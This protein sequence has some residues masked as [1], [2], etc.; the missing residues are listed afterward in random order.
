MKT[1]LTS[2]SLV[3]IAL[4]ASGVRSLS[5]QPRPGPSDWTGVWVLD[6][7]AHAEYAASEYRFLPGGTLVRARSVDSSVSRG[8]GVVPQVG[9]VAQGTTRCEFGDRWSAL[10]GSRVQIAGVCSDGRP[11]GIVLDVGA[12]RGATTRRTPHV[13]SV[14]GEPGW[15]HPGW[16]WELRRC[17]RSTD[18]RCAEINDME[19]GAAGAGAP[20]TGLAGPHGSVSDLAVVAMRQAGAMSLTGIAWEN[21]AGAPVAA[22]G[23]AR[24]E[25]RFMVLRSGAARALRFVWRDEEGWWLAGERESL[26]NAE[27][28]EPRVTL[29]GRGGARWEYV[30]V[31]ATTRARVMVTCAPRGP[32]TRA[33]QAL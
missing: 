27:V 25:A 33:A 20:A 15:S 23:P 16:N 19:L 11:R 32:C 28:S 13:V 12:E 6:E 2:R 14:G 1:P 10:G 7:P 8:S 9:V 22:A 29:D 31:N 3:A 18:A 4:I 26:G 30:R 5:A 17:S 21:L 24:Q